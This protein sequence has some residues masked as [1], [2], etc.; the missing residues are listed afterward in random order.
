MP[1]VGVRGCAKARTQIKMVI[2]ARVMRRAVV[3]VPEARDQM[4][5]LLKLGPGVLRV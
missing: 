4:S 5:P 1:S 3:V 2:R